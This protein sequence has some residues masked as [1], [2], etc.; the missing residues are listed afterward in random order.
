M[1]LFK[2]TARDFYY[3]IYLY[4]GLLP[5][6][7]RVSRRLSG[8]RHFLLSKGEGKHIRLVFKKLLC[9]PSMFS[10]PE[11]KNHV[12]VSLWLYILV[13]LQLNDTIELPKK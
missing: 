5:T 12:A 2:F 4:M 10:K 7:T 3:S 9:N 11:N 8:S 6:L 13:C 1:W